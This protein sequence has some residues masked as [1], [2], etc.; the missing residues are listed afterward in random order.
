MK[1]PRFLSLIPA[2]VLALACG[3]YLVIARRNF[4]K[5]NFRLFTFEDMVNTVANQ[6]QSP[7]DVLPNGQTDQPPIPHT[8]PHDKKVLWYLESLGKGPEAF[9]KMKDP[10][11][12]SY[13][14]MKRGRFVFETFCLPCHGKDGTGNGPVAKAFPPF[15]FSAAVAAEKMSE[16]QIFSIITY[17]KPPMPSYAAQISPDDRWKVALYIKDLARYQEKKDAIEDEKEKAAAQ[18]APQTP[19]EKSG[20]G[21]SF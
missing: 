8:I 19:S 4:N 12:R 6:T 7:N 10:F 13:A 20:G 1:K 9:D 2:I 15:Q 18:A 21:D 11:E 17:G 14:A 5:P 3:G 16:G